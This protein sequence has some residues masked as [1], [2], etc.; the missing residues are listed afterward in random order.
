M[1]SRLRHA[2]LWHTY[3]TVQDEPGQDQD[4]PLPLVDVE[5]DAGERGEDEGPEAGAADGDARGQGPL[6]LEVVADAYHRRQVDQS[7]SDA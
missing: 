6:R 7:K 2:R 4:G 1:L 5:E 3:R